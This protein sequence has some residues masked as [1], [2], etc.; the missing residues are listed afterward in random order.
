MTAVAAMP[1]AVMAAS[2]IAG[3]AGTAAKASTSC[4][5]AAPAVPTAKT[6]ATVAAGGETAS[7][8]AHVRGFSRWN[9]GR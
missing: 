4:R 5:K 1:S 9:E 8:S 7:A 2:K 6:A 3:H